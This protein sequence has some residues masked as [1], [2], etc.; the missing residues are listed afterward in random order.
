M[1][2][3]VRQETLNLLGPFLTEQSNTSEQR[4]A[5]ATRALTDILWRDGLPEFSL[6]WLSDP[7]LTQHDYSP[8]APPSLA[9]IKN[10]DRNLTAVLETLKKKNA[11][12]QTDIFVVSDHGFSTIERGI[13]FPAA[14][15][16]AGFDAVAAFQQAPQAGQVML[17]A[18]Q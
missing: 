6:L 16:A 15:C 13:D 9:A 18:L 12:N 3:T 17:N 8:G 10:S 11:R 1:P 14:L 2:P 5:Y 4:N 7:D